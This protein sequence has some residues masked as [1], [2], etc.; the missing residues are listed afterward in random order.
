MSDLP[1]GWEWT[2]LGDVADVRDG[3]LR[4]ARPEEPSGRT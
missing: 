4:D 1:P 2:T 3:R